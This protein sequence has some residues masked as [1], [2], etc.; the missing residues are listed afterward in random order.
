MGSSSPNT[1][2]QVD[3]TCLREPYDITVQSGR[4]TSFELTVENYHETPWFR[5]SVDYILMYDHR[6]R[7]IMNDRDPSIIPDRRIVSGPT[8]LFTALND[9]GPH[10][11]VGHRVRIELH[12]PMNSV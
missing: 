9:P 2:I 1:P 8:G 11:P 7:Y 12:N 4:S 6:D 10:G 3:D 5:D